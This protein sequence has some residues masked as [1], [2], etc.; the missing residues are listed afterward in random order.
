VTGL[1]AA[2][3][4]SGDCFFWWRFYAAL[5]LDTRKIAGQRRTA[6]LRELLQ[7][8]MLGREERR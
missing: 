6:E 4:S 3:Q 8:G 5:R 7:V 2:D 1:V